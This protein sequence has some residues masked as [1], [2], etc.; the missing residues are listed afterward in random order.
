MLAIIGPSV[1]FL[2]PRKAG[3][4]E[5]IEMTKPLVIAGQEQSALHR[6]GF[7]L[8]KQLLEKYWLL[9]EWT[10]E[11]SFHLYIDSPFCVQQ[12]KFCM[13]N[14]TIL[15]ARQSGI[16]KAYYRELAKEIRSWEQVILSRCL[17]SVYFGGGTSSLMTPAMMNCIFDSIP[18]F[19][20][21]QSKCFECD[22]MT[23]T[24]SK[25]KMLVD[26]GFTYVSFGLQTLDEAELEN[27][28]R[29]NPAFSR[30]KE[31]TDHL[32]DNGIHVSYD[33]MVFL[34]DDMNTDL[35]RFRQDC[36]QILGH[37]KPSAVDVYPMQ[38]SLE[39]PEDEIC[40]KMLEFKRVLSQLQQEYSEYSIVGGPELDKPPEF[41]E[42][43]RNYFFV[44]SDPREYFASVKRYSCSDPSFA[45]AVQNTLGLGG[46][47]SRHVYSY[48]D[49]GDVRYSSTFDAV[50]NRFV[51]F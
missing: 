51:Y 24:I 12:C 48:M 29:S 16:F 46:Y 34:N 1:P 6:K 9:R 2:F 7:P 4:D 3:I 10:S 14:P 41:S 42:R 17:D 27:Q 18:E 30:L 19:A 38:P 50:E 20:R 15:D 8:L 28:G 36:R 22:P 25:I 13:L 47:A 21:I 40:A 39:G 23:L 11:E 44:K 37:L 32:L 31:L 35:S 43:Y 45:P 26:F 33:V 49:G 5:I